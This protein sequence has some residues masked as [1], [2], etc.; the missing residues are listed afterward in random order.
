MCRLLSPGPNPPWNGVPR[1]TICRW[2]LR[3]QDLD[4]EIVSRFIKRYGSAVG[5][6]EYLIEA[7]NEVLMR[8]EQVEASL[9]QVR[10]DLM[11]HE[12]K[13][14]EL[15]REY[16][17][18]RITLAEYRDFKAHVNKE[19][20]EHRRREVQLID[21]LSKMHE[22]LVDDNDLL[23]RSSQVD[24][25]STLTLEQQKATLAEFIVRVTVYKPKGASVADIVI[26]WRR[27][28]TEASETAS[29]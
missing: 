18:R 14:D 16:M 9:G 23:R 15:R 8:I 17:D 27:G 1:N 5:R 6:Q 10:Q 25:W 4:D 20:D 29:A 24:V 3:Q 26:S 11:H 13:L 19:S 7:A 28:T 2:I 22:E 12:K 21:T